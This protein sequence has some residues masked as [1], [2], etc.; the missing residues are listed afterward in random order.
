MPEDCFSCH[1]FHQGSVRCSGQ[2]RVGA[3]WLQI[4]RA[5]RAGQPASAL[6]LLRDADFHLLH[7]L[8]HTSDCDLR[9]VR[10]VLRVVLAAAT[11][12][13]EISAAAKNKDA[14]KAR[15]TKSK[16]AKAFVETG[17]GAKKRGKQRGGDDAE[18]L[19]DQEDS[20]CAVIAKRQA[21]TQSQ[22][23]PDTLVESSEDDDDDEALFA[24]EE[25]ALKHRAQNKRP[26]EGAGTPNTAALSE[27]PGDGGAVAVPVSCEGQPRRSSRLVRSCAAHSVSQ[28][29]VD[30]G[31]ED[32]TELREEDGGG[33]SD[34]GALGGSDSDAECGSEDE[35]DESDFE[36][37]IAQ[38]QRWGPP[39]AT[40]PRTQG[41][42]GAACSK[43]TAPASK[44]RKKLRA[45]LSSG[46]SSLAGGTPPDDG[47]NGNKIVSKA[48]ACATDGSGE[49]VMHAHLAAEKGNEPT[50]GSCH[51][52]PT[53]TRVCHRDNT[54][55][56][57]V[58]LQLRDAAQGAQITVDTI[59]TMLAL[60]E[61]VA[62]NAVRVLGN[63]MPA[64]K[65]A[66]Y[67]RTAEELAERE[68][69]FAA[70]RSV[71][72][73]RNGTLSAKMQ[74]HMFLPPSS[75]LL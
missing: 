26:R 6:V 70:I 44:A 59:Q 69:L 74:V 66:C 64:F 39:G 25:L 28:P 42:S 13:V 22:R 46:P 53:S 55:G 32:S 30:E 49:H 47:P 51:A 52:K 24:A 54:H 36:E 67:K 17:G 48:D 9:A 1:V 60:L 21:R 10:H 12:K 41:S 27:R 5:G 38:K 58:V 37:Q 23:K 50:N 19:K 65:V 29:T 56:N 35:D 63:V 57:Y 14:S 72:R 45:N 3:C 11:A 16:A 2:I 68:P 73:V 71:A 15:A 43:A 62:P 8:K 40:V 34:S 4:G 61:S 33:G 18:D 20:A 75:S 31:L 7:S